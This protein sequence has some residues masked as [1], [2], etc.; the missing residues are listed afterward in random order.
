[1]RIMKTQMSLLRSFPLKSLLLIGMVILMDGCGPGRYR[2]VIYAVPDLQDAD[3]YIDSKLVRSKVVDVT[4][5]YLSNERHELKVIQKG[6]KPFVAILE[7][8]TPEERTER[9]FEVKFEPL[10]SVPA[11]PSSQSDTAK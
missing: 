10:D 9:A 2:L 7:P 11:T 1:M 5:I 6:Y 4:H 3:I 8:P